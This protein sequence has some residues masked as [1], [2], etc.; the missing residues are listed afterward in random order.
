MH[1]EDDPLTFSEISIFHLEEFCGQGLEQ[2]RAGFRI[3][4]YLLNLK[5]KVL[6]RLNVFKR[7][8]ISIPTHPAITFSKLTIKALEK[9]VKYV[10][11]VNN[12]AN[13]VFIINFEH[14]SHL[15]QVFLLLTLSR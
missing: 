4:S 9:D 3:F 14:I 7:Q 1:H 12:K 2:E 13:D 5:P 8:K 11:K 6:L 15:V 10:N